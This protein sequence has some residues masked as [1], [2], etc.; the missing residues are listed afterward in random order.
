MKAVEAHASI[1]PDSKCFSFFQ[2]VSRVGHVSVQLQDLWLI[3][4]VLNCPYRNQRKCIHLWP[5][6][7]QRGVFTDHSWAKCEAA[8]NK[9]VQLFYHAWDT[10]TVMLWQSTIKNISRFKNNI[11]DKLKP[12]WWVWV[13]SETDRKY[14]SWKGS[15]VRSKRHFTLL[16]MWS[17]LSVSLKTSWTLWASGTDRNPADYTTYSESGH[18]VHSFIHSFV[19]LYLCGCCYSRSE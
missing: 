2:A 18:E 11:S 15:M 8:E 3:S 16:L 19:S 9:G 7:L 5:G 10:L 1:S 13:S 14:Q 17:I 4:G 12:S 6:G